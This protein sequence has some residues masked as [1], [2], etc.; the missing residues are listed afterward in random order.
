VAHWHGHGLLSEC[1]PGPLILLRASRFYVGGQ[2]N[3]MDKEGQ[4][5]WAS[6][7]SNMVEMVT[8]QPGM[9]K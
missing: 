5:T 3:Q 9:C 8:Q 2:V 1:E 7:P 4:S 6:P